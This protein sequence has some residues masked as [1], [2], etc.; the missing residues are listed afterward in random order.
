MCAGAA[1]DGGGGLAA[2][3]PQP[4]HRRYE[5]DGGGVGAAAGG[6]APRAALLPEADPAARKLPLQR[7]GH[8]PSAPDVEAATGCEDFLPDRPGTDRLTLGTPRS[9]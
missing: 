8:R 6:H 3:W 5:A 7:P 2:A 4:P 1:R 9:G